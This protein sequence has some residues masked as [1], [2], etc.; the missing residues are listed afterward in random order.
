VKSS[1]A[2][3]LRLA[4]SHT[5]PRELRADENYALDPQRFKDL[6]IPTLLLEGSDSRAFEKK[7]NEALAAAL[8]DSRI[9]VL[10]GQK[11]IAMY[12]APDLFLQEI[13]EFLIEPE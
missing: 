4:I 7:G 1:P 11:H 13:L 10:P 6:R 9:V 2:W 12:T 8:P 5:L 3:P